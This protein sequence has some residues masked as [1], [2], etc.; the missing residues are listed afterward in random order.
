MPH[1]IIKESSRKILQLIEKTLSNKDTLVGKWSMNEIAT[2]E[3]ETVRNKLKCGIERHIQLRS[4]Q[5]RNKMIDLDTKI[6]KN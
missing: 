5:T 4:V 6:T 3:L 1:I 2:P